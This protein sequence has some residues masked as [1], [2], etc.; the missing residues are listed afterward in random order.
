MRKCEKVRQIS[1][2]Y[3]VCGKGDGSGFCMRDRGR[4]GGREAGDSEMAGTMVSG[5][6]LTEKKLRLCCNTGAVLRA[7]GCAA[8]PESSS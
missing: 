7:E 3:T 6:T 2:K 8:E 5:V 4:E 1:N